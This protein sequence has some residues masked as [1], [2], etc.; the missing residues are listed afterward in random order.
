ML[1]GCRRRVLRRSPNFYVRLN[2]NPTVPFGYKARPGSANCS[3]VFVKCIVSGKHIVQVHL[4]HNLKQLARR[5]VVQESVLRVIEFA[6][7]HRSVKPVVID[8]DFESAFIL[9]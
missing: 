3:N 6:T 1:A 9:S 5:F 2:K 4:G 8:V 7:E